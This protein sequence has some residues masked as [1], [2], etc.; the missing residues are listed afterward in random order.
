MRGGQSRAGTTACSLLLALVCM[1]AFQGCGWLGLR[2]N[3]SQSLPVGLYIA[4][5]T[6]GLIVFCPAE[7]YAGLAIARGTAR[8]A[9]VL[10]AARRC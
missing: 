4:S 7:P 3:T 2:L 8:R 6:G 10:M 5:A 9:S 1:G